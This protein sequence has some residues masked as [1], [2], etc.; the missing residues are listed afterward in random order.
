MLVAGTE[1]LLVFGGQDFKGALGDMYEL[2]LAPQGHYIGMEWSR[3]DT[4]GMPPPPSAKHEAAQVRGHM[5]LVSGE[6]AWQGHLWAL[7]LET[8]MTWFR[9]TV[10]EFPLVG[11]SRHAILEYV[12]PRPH[13]RVST[14]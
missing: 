1:R 3:P 14:T 6:P 5:L 9:S 7:K 13:E 10:G 4:K 11:I 2:N 12:T 8:P